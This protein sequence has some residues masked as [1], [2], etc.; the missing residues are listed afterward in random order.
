MKLAATVGSNLISTAAGLPKNVSA[1]FDLIRGFAPE[2]VISD[3]ASWIY[4]YG[5]AHGLPVISID[6]QQIVHRCKH[7]AEV[8]AGH[9]LDFQLTRTFVKSKLPS[10]CTMSS[11]PSSS[12]RSASRRR[13][14]T[15]SPAGGP[16]RA[17]HPV[18]APPGLPD[19]PGQRRPRPHPCGYGHGVPDLRHAA[20]DI[21]GAGRRQLAL[22]PFRRG[23]LHFRPGVGPG[24]D[25]R[26][27]VHGARRGRLPAQTHALGA[28]SRTVP[29]GPKRPLAGAPGL[30]M[31]CR[32]AQDPAVVHRFLDAIPGCEEKLASYRQDG[33]ER[34]YATVEEVLASE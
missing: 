20:G 30:W 25:L 34:L 24:G 3:F 21:R 14:A 28:S 8:V 11:R 1:W 5:K 7:P 13:L 9:E 23:R 12:P 16:C 2:T 19:S 31:L 27:R 4:L 26:R 6:N 17:L 22:P 29:A 33:N 15:H 10:A 32:V 18:G